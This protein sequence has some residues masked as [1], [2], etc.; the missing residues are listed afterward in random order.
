MDVNER[1][2]SMLRMGENAS[3]SGHSNEGFDPT[4]TRMRDS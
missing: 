1:G 4:F 2:Q 3:L